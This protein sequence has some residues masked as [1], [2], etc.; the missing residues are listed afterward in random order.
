MGRQRL[1]SHHREVPV[2]ALGNIALHE[3]L[4]VVWHP[5]IGE[6]RTLERESD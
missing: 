2:I 5:R 4:D 3:W 6:T 1:R